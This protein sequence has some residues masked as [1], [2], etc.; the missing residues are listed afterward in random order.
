MHASLCGLIGTNPRV[1]KELADVVTRPL[2][3]FFSAVLRI[4]KGP[5]KHEGSKCSP[6]FPEGQGKGPWEKHPKRLTVAWGAPGSALPAGKERDCL[7][8]PGFEVRLYW[9]EQAPSELNTN[10]EEAQPAAPVLL[11]CIAGVLEG[12]RSW[13]KKERKG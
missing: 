8:P 6:S 9:A 1:L 13:S 4:W 3:I 12:R 7:T 2:S 5:S 10:A 11:N